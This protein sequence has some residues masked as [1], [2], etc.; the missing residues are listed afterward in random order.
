MCVDKERRTAACDVVFVF[1]C[2]EFLLYKY[3]YERHGRI[4]VM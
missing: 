4:V 3:L 1:V 2:F